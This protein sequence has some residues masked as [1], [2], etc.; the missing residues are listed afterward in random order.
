M[1]LSERLAKIPRGNTCPGVNRVIIEHLLT[2][3]TDFEDTAFM[4]V[5]CGDGSFL[6]AVKDFF[7]KGKSF[8]ADINPPPQN[9][10]HKFFKI[11]A[12]RPFDIDADEEFKIITSISGVTEFDNTQL[13]LEQLK[14]WLDPNGLLIVTNDNIFSARN[15]IL[16]LFFGRFRQTHLFMADDEPT[17]KI[18]PLQNLIRILYEAGFEVDEIKYVPAKFSEWLWLPVAALIYVFQYMY[19]LFAETGVKLSQKTSLY[20]FI[21]FIS[22]HYVLICRKRQ[23]DDSVS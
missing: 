7:P 17:W 23:Q 8:G 9:S 12:R 19:L 10:Q 15:R 2:L 3:D 11:D 1:K 5:P 6:N 16:Y 14:K 22:R 18:I 20:P 13:F 4:D 21:S